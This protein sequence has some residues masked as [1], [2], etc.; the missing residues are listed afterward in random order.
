MVGNKWISIIHSQARV[1]HVFDV[2]ECECEAHPTLAYIACVIEV[3]QKS[4]FC[5]IDN[6]S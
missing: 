2:V 3:G 5:K 6:C 4:A 1:T